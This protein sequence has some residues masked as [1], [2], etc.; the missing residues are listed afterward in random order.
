[1]SGR[2]SEGCALTCPMTPADTRGALNSAG[3]PEPNTGQWC[4]PLSLLTVAS[5]G[6]SDRLCVTF[7]HR[8]CM[9]WFTPLVLAS[10]PLVMSCAAPP[11]SGGASSAVLAQWSGQQGGSQTAGD[12]L[13]RT[14]EEWR[15][16]WQQ[17]GREP[18]RTLDVARELGVVVFLGQ[19][20]TGGYSVE[21]VDVRVQGDNQV[22]TF[23]ET[24]PH[25]GGMTTQALTSPWAIAVVTRSDR[26][27]VVRNL[28]P[29]E[30]GV[31]RPEHSKRPGARQE[32]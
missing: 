23:R 11:P 20:A 24:S 26:P 19:R 18:P 29:R 15:G 8:P 7:T 28:T 17:V 27:T 13:L 14:A 22:V 6:K 12:R 31:Q 9:K 10:V 4:Y 25:A 32:R 30:S 16:V 3:M 2:W 1:M 21:I 5:P